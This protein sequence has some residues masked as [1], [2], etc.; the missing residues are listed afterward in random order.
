[1]HRLSSRAHPQFCLQFLIHSTFLLVC[2]VIYYCCCF[3]FLSRIT[4][5][6]DILAGTKDP[7]PTMQVGIKSIN[8]SVSLITFLTWLKQQ[9]ATTQVEETVKCYDWGRNDGIST[10]LVVKC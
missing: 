2:S 10:F 6:I 3:A 1:M 8:K 4:Q 7:L 9:T 5:D